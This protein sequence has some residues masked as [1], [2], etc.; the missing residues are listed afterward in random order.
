MRLAGR[1]CVGLPGM[2]R[3]LGAVMMMSESGQP[4]VRR[5]VEQ[6]AVRL[7]GYSQVALGRQVAWFHWCRPGRPS[8]GG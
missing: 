8:E 6:L 1:S 5:P 4:P 7:A 3:G 2:V